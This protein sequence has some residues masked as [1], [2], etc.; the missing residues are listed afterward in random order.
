MTRL[1]F[2]FRSYDIVI[3]PN[4]HYLLRILFVYFMHFYVDFCHR[5]PQGIDAEIVRSMKM[6]GPIGYAPNPKTSRRNQ[7]RMHKFSTLF[8]GFQSLSL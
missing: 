4:R 7:V 8:Y 1:I 2:V 6:Q 3:Y 5:K